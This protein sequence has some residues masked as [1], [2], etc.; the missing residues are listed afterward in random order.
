MLVNFKAA[1]AARRVKQIDLALQLKLDPT[2]LSRIINRRCEADASLRARLAAALEVEE[3]WLFQTVA[4]IPKAVRS[5][6]TE[7]SGSLAPAAV[8]CSEA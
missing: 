3:A 5:D 7:G 2:F 4:R 8:R 6:S 1:L